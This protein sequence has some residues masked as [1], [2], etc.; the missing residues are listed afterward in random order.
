MGHS[1]HFEKARDFEDFIFDRPLLA[2]VELSLNLQHSNRDLN[3]FDGRKKKNV[4]EKSSLTNVFRLY[5]G[6]TSTTIDPF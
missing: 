3:Y 2:I 6:S 1:N 5:Y 4:N